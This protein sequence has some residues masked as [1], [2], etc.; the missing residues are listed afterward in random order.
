LGEI[1]FALQGTMTF[2]LTRSIF[3]CMWLLS[4]YFTKKFSRSPLEGRASIFHSASPFQLFQ[5][6]LEGDGRQ[7]RQ[8][9]FHHF[10]IG[11][12]RKV[13]SSLGRKFLQILAESQQVDQSRFSSRAQM[14]FFQP[15]FLINQRWFPADA[16]FLPIVGVCHGQVAPSRWR[17]AAGCPG[18]LRGSGRGWRN[19][20][21]YCWGRW[22]GNIPRFR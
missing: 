5:Q 1:E 22:K 8:G 2:W 15:F 13:G 16:E 17:T 20:T 12:G 19:A 10:V 18:S 14:N 3:L 4:G 11:S 21:V 7:G 9:P 6:V